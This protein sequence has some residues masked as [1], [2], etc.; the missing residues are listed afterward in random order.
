MARTLNNIGM[1]LIH[2]ERY[3]DILEYQIRAMTIYQKYYQTNHVYIA[4]T[5][6]IIGYV[7]Y[8][9]EKLD[10]A[11]NIYQRA[12]VI[13][14][15][16][17]PYNRMEFIRF[18]L[19]YIGNVLY[20]RQKYTEA[21]Y[22]E[23][24][25]GVGEKYYPFDHIDMATIYYN[26]ALA[27]QEEYGDSSAR[28]QV[29][30]TL[31][32][33]GH[34]QYTT[35][36]SGCELPIREKHY[37]ISHIT[38]IASLMSIGRIKFKQL[39]WNRTIDYY[40]RAEVLLREFHPTKEAN[41]APEHS[42]IVRILSKLSE[43]QADRNQHRLAL[44]YEMQCYLIREKVLPPDDSDIAFSLSCI[45]ESYEHLNELKLALEY[46]KR[47]L[48]IYQ[49][50]EYIHIFKDSI[51]EMQTKIKEISTKIINKPTGHF[52]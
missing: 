38:I 27:I 5:L 10:E 48:I 23:R 35:S 49:Q 37:T 45:G 14:K 52:V 28:I 19:L 18:T 41:L 15:K 9:Q 2:G 40:S 20:D 21:T 36:R 44:T 17:R 47:A 32:Y 33:I 34:I 24:A 25:M 22:Y 16:L 7:L 4:D 51:E 13:S 1:F 8:R 30:D 42:S 11:L 43:A 12:L 39:D 6:C 29:A 31:L 50:Q 26:Q 46:Y 3:D